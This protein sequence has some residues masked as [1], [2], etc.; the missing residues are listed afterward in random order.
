MVNRRKNLQWILLEITFHFIKASTRRQT[1]YEELK[2]RK[3]ANTAK[4][5]MARQMLKVIYHVLKEQRPYY[6]DAAKEV[7][8]VNRIQPVAAA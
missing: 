6:E 4:V 1:R 2:D 8:P 7:K 3:G 5:I